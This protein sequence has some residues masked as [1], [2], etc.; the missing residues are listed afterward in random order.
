MKP[1]Y[2]IQFPIF[3]KATPLP[4]AKNAT[5]D[6]D[7][8]NLFS[9]STALSNTDPIAQQR[10]K[11]ISDTTPPELK[12]VKQ[13]S[14]N[15]LALFT[16]NKHLAPEISL[17]IK[18]EEGTLV[19]ESSIEINTFTALTQPMKDFLVT[20]KARMNL[21]E[22]ENTT[23]DVLF[24]EEFPTLKITS[25]CANTFVNHYKHLVHAAQ[26]KILGIA[27][28]D[29]SI[30]ITSFSALTQ[31]MKDFLVKAKVRMNQH[32][33]E[34]KSLDILFAEEFPTQRITA[35]CA[36]NFINHYRHLVQ[37][38]QNSTLG[39]PI[40]EGII[41]I[42]S[43]ADLTQPM[44]DFLVT[45][46]ARMKLQHIKNRTLDSL[47]NEEFPTHSITSICA[48]NFVR[49][50]KHLVQTAQNNTLGIKMEEGIIEITSVTALTQPMKNFLVTAKARI[51]LQQIKNKTLDVLFA[52]EFPTYTITPICANNFVKHYRHLVETAQ[53]TLSGL[54]TEEGI[55]EI[56]S[57]KALTQPM[58]D[59]L[60]QTRAR[61]QRGEIEN[62]TLETLFGAEFPSHRI[63]YTCANS[64]VN[65][66]RH[67][68]QQEQHKLSGTDE[69]RIELTSAATLT[70]PMKDFLVA[71][72][73]RIK[74][75]EIKNKALDLL[76]NEE[77]PAYKITR[78]CAN[79]FVNHHKQ[80]L[81]IEQ[82]KIL[83]AQSTTSA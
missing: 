22:I 78:I 29:G 4:T 50:Y 72:K 83:G 52:E 27:I 17:G 8:A 14:F 25:V 44:K 36:N 59:F 19:E 1:N 37:T 60:L 53:N 51:K 74:L 73:A 55:I 6:S 82:H 7:R 21:Q 79:N 70:Q 64:F 42:T 41:A 67:L 24:N 32:E 5:I 43:F 81:Q 63:T 54:K 9:A 23:L 11:F 2:N 65:H 30:Q 69:N 66:Y 16:Q 80:L 68:V 3:A 28:E 18:I 35:I 39:I 47:F 75:H 10:R 12:R 15:N 62:K 20:T 71:T 76:F 56:T 48:N 58:K 33:I 38:A 49:H 31:P 34:N 61:I 26:H 45:T 46:K 57:F 40:K 77:F 13:N